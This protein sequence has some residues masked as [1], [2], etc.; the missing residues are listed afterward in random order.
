MIPAAE[1]D[2]ALQ[3]VQRIE[4]ID[5]FEQELRDGDGGR[6]RSL[7][8]ATL[9]AGAILTFDRY[10]TLSLAKVHQT[11][12]VDLP[13]PLQRRLGIRDAE[14]K[15]ISVRQVRY[16]WNEIT[17][18]FESSEFYRPEMHPVDRGR[19]Q[20]R[21]AAFTDQFTRAA[22]L[23]IGMTG[24][25]AVDAT[26]IESAARGKKGNEEIL[27]AR[28]AVE[29]ALAAMAA[30]DPTTLGRASAMSVA[31]EH[32]LPVDLDAMWGYRTKT[33]DNKTDVVF[34]YQCIAGTRIPPVGGADEPL[35]VEFIALVP[36]NQNGVGET[37]EALDRL[38]AD[39]VKTREIVADRGFSYA[40]PE[41]WADRL[42][43]RGI[44]QVLDLH[45]NDRGALLH[46]DDGY[47]M[48]DGW[49]HCPSIPDHLKK[50]QR[51]AR[52]KVAEEVTHDAQAKKPGRRSKAKEAQR[53]TD[54]AELEAF[55]DAIADRAQY[56]FERHGR[57][58][59]GAQRFK[60][61]ARAGKL[62]CGGC[63]LSLD[64][65]GVPQV[66]VPT[67]TPPTA[68]KQETISIKSSVQPKLQQREYWGSPEWID[69]YIR[70][71][72]AEGGFGLLKG[73]KTGGVKRGW[74]HQMG[75]ANTAF[76]LAIAFGA[77]NLR[78]L[79]NWSERTGDTRDPLTQIDISSHGFL[80]INPHGGLLGE[81]AMPEAA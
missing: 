64:L 51:P 74:I 54:R 43:D 38:R 40:V 20:D 57:T 28:K 75:H 44:E 62:R 5:E 12:T 68:C 46:D 61:P 34:G 26:A 31:A 70:R 10:Q 33:Y 24:R 23:H 13:A 48:I 6:P 17:D 47:L 71:V 37:I 76:A 32:G 15:V 22:S 35:L 3:Y 56:R 53:T 19:A 14:G 65:E 77:T 73:A 39:G 7:A 67:S 55:Q 45:K 21:L 52:L 81:D 59:S 11:L 63:P 30:D 18:L 27:E 16:L 29:A 41:K 8:V 1:F 66:A 72:R 80:E 69:S 58:G 2:R 49:P 78:Q 36:G 79:L 60:C 50:I 42:R 25:W 4:I 9:I